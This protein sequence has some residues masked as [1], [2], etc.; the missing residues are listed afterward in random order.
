MK[1]KGSKSQLDDDETEDEEE[2]SRDSA[3]TRLVSREGI[4]MTDPQNVTKAPEGPPHINHG[5]TVADL[6]NAPITNHIDINLLKSMM[7]ARAASLGNAPNQSMANACLLNKAG[8]AN[9][10][11]VLASNRLARTSILN[12]HVQDS[13]VD[14]GGS[15]ANDSFSSRKETNTSFP[16]PSGLSS[17]K[18]ELN[19]HGGAA[20]ELSHLEDADTS[21]LQMIAAAVEAGAKTNNGGTSETQVMDKPSEAYGNNF[22]DNHGINPSLAALMDN[23]SNGGN[24]LYMQTLQSMMQ[25]QQQQQ[26]QQ[27]ANLGGFPSELNAGLGAVSGPSNNGDQPNNAVSPNANDTYRD[28]SKVGDD[29]SEFSPNNPPGKE[30]PFPVK[31]HRILTNPEYS[32]VI[33]WLPH[34]RSWRVLK[35]KAFEEKVIPLYF[36]H[37]KYAS[38]MRQVSY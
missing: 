18:N 30:P 6:S 32:D 26:Q 15:G 19:E 10:Q 24:A 16:H 17:I 23:T 31:L 21:A 29:G 22:M 28:F 25:Q 20:S 9:N 34:G 3:S 12:P 5:P 33:S 1:T 7:E 14:T 2:L 36:R 11:D 35:P 38:F 37:A 8:L 27:Q 4:H 13:A